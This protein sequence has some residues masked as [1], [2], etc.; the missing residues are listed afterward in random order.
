MKK[1]IS[2]LAFVSMVYCSSAQTAAPSA[3]EQ[4]LTD[5]ICKDLSRL[6]LNKINGKEEAEAAFTNSFASHTDLLMKLAEEQHVDF[7]DEAG[8]EKI[9]VK[10]GKDLMAMNCEAFTKISFKMVEDKKKS[11][12]TGITEGTFKR[13]DTKSFNYI[14]VAD[15]NKSEKSFLWLREFSGSDKFTGETAQYAGKKL[16]VE[17]REIEVYLPQAKGYYKVKEITGI[18]LL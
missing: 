10:I 9:G 6:D 14:V 5:S 7:N 11:E 16:K 2:L 18:T 1:I 3:T 13:I 17:W 8:M 4:R 15:E 12:G